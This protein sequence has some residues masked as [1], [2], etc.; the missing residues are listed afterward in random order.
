MT[1]MFAKYLKMTDREWLNDRPASMAEEAPNDYHKEV[2][3]TIPAGTPLI[4]D[5]A[6][7]FGMYALA[8]VDGVLHKVKITIDHFHK[9]DF[10][11][12]VNLSAD[13]GAAV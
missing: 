11:P 10:G 13:C 6:G 9:V 1:P 8:D 3:P 5:F 12:S 7:D 2:L 4:C